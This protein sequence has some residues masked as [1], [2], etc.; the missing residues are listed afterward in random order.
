[1]QRVDA[2]VYGLGADESTCTHLVTPLNITKCIAAVGAK[3]G[4][5]MLAIT[6]YSN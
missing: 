3:F 6:N 4:N 1:M 2:L 5:N